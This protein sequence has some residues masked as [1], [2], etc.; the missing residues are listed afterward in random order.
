MHP[1]PAAPA[2]C[3]NCA[4]ALAG[5]YCHACGEK[6]VDPEH[7]FSVRHFLEEA[8]EGFTHFDSRVARTFTALFANPGHLTAEFI[9]GRRVR[10]LKPIPM[11]LLAGVLFYLFMPRTTSFFAN[12]GDLIR[13]FENHRY[14]SNLLRV[15]AGHLLD[16]IA[17]RTHQTPDEA[18]NALVPEAAQLSKAWLWVIAPLWGTLLWI[19]LHRR[20]RWLVPH[21]VFALHGLAFFVL[22]DLFGLLAARGF[23]YDRLGDTYT[24][25]LAAVTGVY[26]VL[27]SRRAYRLRPIAALGVGGLATLLL[28]VLLLIY[29]QVITI[30]TLY[31]A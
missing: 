10:Y 12:V 9:A 13:A 8:V 11:F 22:F 2:S 4:T 26:C 15:D 3:A 5:P 23:G 27:A 31:R 7:D 16:A 17:S 21:L 19:L 20:I 24:Y 18:W 30:V 14:L 25:M 29:R 1:T 6:V 28:L